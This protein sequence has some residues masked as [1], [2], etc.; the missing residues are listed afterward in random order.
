M[1]RITEEHK[2]VKTPVTLDEE[3]KAL[4]R[5]LGIV[6]SDKPEELAG[7]LRRYGVPLSDQPNHSAL[8]DA[9]I[10]AM[11][12]KNNEFNYDLALLF[13]AQV[14]PD[15]NDSFVPSALIKFS[16]PR[17]LAV[18]PSAEQIIA[19]SMKKTFQKGLATNNI[20]LIQ[21]KGKQES[22]QSMG[23]YQTHKEI[24]EKEEGQADGKQSNGLKVVGTMGVMAVAALL[25]GIAIYQ[26]K[27]SK[28]VPLAIAT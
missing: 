28:A 2:K 5:L 9:T 21:Q 3:S 6:I 20:K 14:I 27:K 23:N 12:K 1:V 11:S 22:L 24:E 15:N 10:L 8:A 18:K 17:N 19:A 4:F 7:L 13:A 25:T 16:R 26:I